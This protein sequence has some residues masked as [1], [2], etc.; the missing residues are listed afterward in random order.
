MKGD[1]HVSCHPDR[2]IGMKFEFIEICGGA[3]VVTKE[4]IALG[5]AVDPS[6]MFL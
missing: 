4:L 1:Q 3:G 6:L 2:P 5:L